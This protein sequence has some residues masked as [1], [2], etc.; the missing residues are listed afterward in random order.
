MKTIKC[1]GIGKCRA[2]ARVAT[3]VVIA[4]EKGVHQIST[5]GAIIRTIMHMADVAD[6]CWRGH[7]GFI[8]DDGNAKV[9]IISLNAN[10][11]AEDVR[12]IVLSSY[13]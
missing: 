13:A 8:L 6:F 2:V 9:H 5:E 7:E 3:D 12:E 10:K 11:N 1:H 4:S